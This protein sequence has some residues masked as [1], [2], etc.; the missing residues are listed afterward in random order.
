MQTCSSLLKRHEQKARKT[1]R[2]NEPRDR[3]LE[4]QGVRGNLLLEK[5]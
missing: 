2:S 1:F 5:P 3:V 4:M